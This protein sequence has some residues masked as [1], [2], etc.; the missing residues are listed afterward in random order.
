[1]GAI[2]F[3]EGG[4]RYLAFRGLGLKNPFAHVWPVAP[5][6]GQITLEEIAGIRF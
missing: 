6:R 3:S 4:V 5:R 1:M 2:F